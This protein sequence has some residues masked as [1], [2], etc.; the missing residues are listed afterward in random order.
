MLTK[1]R[2]NGNLGHCWCVICCSHFG[3]QFDSSSKCWANLPYDLTI[4]PLGIYVHKKLCKDVHSSIIHHSQRVETNQIPSTDE[5]IHKM[6]NIHTMEYYLAIKRN[7]ILP[8]DTTWMNLEMLCCTKEAKH[9]KV[10]V[11]WLH[12]YTIQIG[13]ICRDRR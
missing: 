2:R 11:V 13:Q 1:V 7:K 8:R 5:W 10:H 6:W 12:L 3:K 9:E 4:L